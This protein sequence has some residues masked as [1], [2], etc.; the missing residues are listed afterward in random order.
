MNN[1]KSLLATKLTI[2]CDAPITPPHINH[3]IYI[4]RNSD[5]SV[6]TKGGSPVMCNGER[7]VL[8]EGEFA[9][10][11]TKADGSMSFELKCKAPTLDIKGLI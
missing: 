1:T 7:L 4:I 9:E 10:L 2:P 6:S 11:I 3:M 5:G 8:N